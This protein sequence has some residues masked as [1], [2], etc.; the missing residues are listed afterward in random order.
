MNFPP[1]PGSMITPVKGLDLIRGRDC[2]IFSKGEAYAVTVDQ[3]MLVGGW[4][5]GQA[6]QWIDSP[7]STP[8]VSYS[9]GLC[10]GFL[11]FGSMESADL[12]TALT[13]NVLKYPDAAV[14][15]VGNSLISTATY[16]RYTYASRTGGGPLVPLVYGPGDLLYFSLR[17]LWTNEQELTLSGHPMAPNSFVGFVCQLPAKTN[18]F[19]LGIQTSL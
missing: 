1:P 13:G 14:M 18:Q 19:F 16:E 3:K 7:L 6:A 8:V 11:P 17:G 10:G 15:M 2:W 4:A 9:M 12:Y 5:G